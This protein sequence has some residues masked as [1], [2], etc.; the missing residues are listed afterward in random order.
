MRIFSKLLQGDSA[1][2][3]DDALIDGNNRD[4]TSDLYTLSYVIAGP[5][6]QPLTLTADPDGGGWK[7]TLTTTAS[8]AL[9][10]GRYWWQAVLT[11]ATERIT[12]DSG[13]LEIKQNIALAGASFDGR[14]PAEKALSDAEAALSQY[15][16][17]GGRIKSYTI[18]TRTMTFEDGSA[19][20]AQISY[21][22]IKVRTEQGRS[23]NLLARFKR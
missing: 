14:T 18:G 8:A 4:L 16:A 9:V 11:S 1:F 13:E 6:A 17:S 20:L 15:K 5:I 7:T 21:W 3:I 19:I 12:V 2:W 23:R 22:K 10:P